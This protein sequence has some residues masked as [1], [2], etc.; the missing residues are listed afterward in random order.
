MATQIADGLWQLRMGWYG[1]IAT[2]V[3]LLD[4]GEVT[5]VDTGLRW[6]RRSIRTE[7]ADA[8]YDVTDL[9]RVL[10][11]HYDLDHTNGLAQLAP[12][13]DGP[14]Y[15]SQTDL[16]LSRGAYDPPLFHHKGLFHRLVRPFFPISEEFDVRYVD[17]EHL[18]GFETYHTPGHNPGHVVY[19]HDSGVA[20]LGDLVWE[21]QGGLT[22]PFWLD[23]YNM[24]ALHESIVSL[25]DHVGHFEVGAVG[26]GTPI[27]SDGYD[28]L[29]R[30]AE[31]LDR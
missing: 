2:N 15:V 17:D 23:S 8:G 11:T 20:F 7:L 3:Y 5:L 21:E 29:Q 30:L 25:A 16:D 6:N 13:F 22:P 14:V 31:Q 27:R 24:R 12:E 9:D 18:D 19:V 28:A 10:I 1:P 4:D 26:H